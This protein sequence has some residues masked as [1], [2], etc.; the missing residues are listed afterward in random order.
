MVHSQV[1]WAGLAA[2]LATLTASGQGPGGRAPGGASPPAMPAEVARSIDAA[3]V[4]R[5][6]DALAG[7]GTRHTMS[8]TESPTRGIGAARR[9]LKAEFERAAAAS[10]GRMEVTF[11]EFEVPPGGPGSRTPEG[12]KV[13]NVV[14]VLRGTSEAAMGKGMGRRYYVVGHY[15]TRNSGALDVSADAPGANDDASGT[16]VVLA[17]ARALAARP[18]E[19]T[20]VFLC[21]AGEEQGLLGAKLHA[22]QAAASGVPILG[23]LSND[24][25]GDP[26]APAGFPAT[27]AARSLVRVFSEGIPRNATAEGLAKIRSLAAEGDSPSRALARYVEDVGRAY[28]LAVKARLVWRPDR[29]LRGGDHSAFNEAVVR[30]ATWPRFAWAGWT[31]YPAVRFTE[32]DE[33]YSRQ[34][35]TPRIETGADG[36]PVQFGDL[37]EYVDAEYV[38]DVARLNAAALACL[39]NAPTPPANV[40]IITAELTNTT[41]LRWE[42]SPEADVAGYEVVW[43]ETTSARW[44]HARDAGA[45]LEATIELSKDDYFFGVRAYDRDGY[46]SPVVFAGA[47][48]R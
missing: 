20:I 48:A 23:V 45:A 47:A 37:P 29:F 18:A 13:V 38:A 16:A 1:A 12:A 36:R 22:E 19:A 10:G 9:W 46:R 24:I 6:V 43:R 3:Q 33:D 5:D 30:E 35:Q 27:P 44:E 7:F 28:D 21:T 32:L 17:C 42:A 14:A 4:R 40:R 15:D 31:G 2:G 34:H 11:E 25:V 8:E 41:T 26:T 39:A